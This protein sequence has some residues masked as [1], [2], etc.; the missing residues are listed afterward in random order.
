MFFK[1]LL[2]K[3]ADAG[4][5]AEQQ[6]LIA[7]A[8][9]SPD[10][11]VRRDACRQLSDLAALRRLAAEDDDAAVR[12]LAGARYRR[13]LCGLDAQSPPLELRLGELGS[14][15]DQ[16]LI[17]DVAGQ[18]EE[19]E[20]R[21]AAIARLSRPEALAACAIDDPL[22]AN[23]LA[24]AERVQDKAALEHIA[25]GI[26]KRDKR[27][28]RLARERLRAIAE[29]EERPRLA[30]EQGEALCTKLERLGRFDNWVQDRAV[31]D[32]LDQQWE[33]LSTDAGEPL[34]ERY[35]ALRRRFLD[36]YDAYAREHAAQLAA[37][38]AR[39]E[40]VRTR[41]ALIAELE[42]L[43]ALEDLAALDQGLDDNTRAWDS[44]P[45]P[46]PAA[47]RR[48]A[49]A[50][51]AALQ[52]LRSHREHLR[53]RRRHKQTSERLLGEARQL[54]EQGGVPERKTLRALQGRFEVL[55]DDAPQHAEIT[56]LLEQLHRRFDKHCKQLAR[57]LAA[58]PERLAEL[59][60]HFDQ[61]ELKKAEP[62]YQSIGATLEHA[63]A[64]GLPKTDIA[65]VDAH[66]KQIA[67][68]LHELRQWRRWSADEHRA[69]LCE[70][71]ETLAADEER[72]L[73]QAAARL[74]ELQR[75]W[76]ELDRNGAPPSNALWQRFHE[77][78]ERVHER[79]RPFLD[80][81]AALRAEN[82][83]QRE[84]LCKRLEEFMEQVDWERID[85][86]K[87]ARAEREMRQA[88]AALG[89]VEGRHHKPL[90]GRFRRDLR[91]LDKALSEERERNQA[92]KRSLIEQMQALADEPDLRRAIDAAKALQQQ[93]HTTVAGRQ[94]DEN[95]LWK[96]FRGASDAVFARRQAEHEAKTAELRDNQAA[97]EA[98][99][100]ELTVLTTAADMEPVRFEQALRALKTR[101]QD[102]EALPLPRSAAAGLARQWRAAL[103]EAGARLEA[104]RE[105]ARWAA[106]ERL[107]ARAA[108]LDE[109]AR[110][111]AA[112]VDAQAEDLKTDWSALPDLDDADA[113]AAL[114]ER[115]GE[116]LTALDDAAERAALVDRLDQNRERRRELCL[117][118]EIVAGVPSPA[119]LKEQRMALQVERLRGRMGEG[120]ADPLADAG[121]LLRDWY[122]STPAAADVDLDGRFTRVKEG[123]G[124]H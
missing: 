31:L 2:S 64:A 34:C 40:S 29:A 65:P 14:A 95:A 44:A 67:P 56:A 58:L 57:R 94:R 122:L 78:G 115:F 76:R 68:R 42:Q 124:A 123:L 104:L 81:Q 114:E 80:Q 41:E 6:Q 59:D 39:A 16:S 120:E 69:G 90:E 12:D 33:A 4:D 75:E 7:A 117:H 49:Q 25:K 30:R 54:L 109:T 93:W 88:W 100:Q 55:P 21:L 112:G 97:R 106:T 46:E 22:A 119:A 86:K 101:W 73:D 63:R 8:L 82:R 27:V 48:L 91:R 47:A 89:P 19:P 70:A 32:H 99:C 87:L 38:Q 77:A 111:L 66:L 26:G 5:P 15:D 116:V 92:H 23:R 96:S 45:E 72:P 35:Q 24:A 84:A 79:C 3:K 50:R 1:R 60:A 71:I 43:A 105:A 10:A 20:L 18:A 108:W 102:T 85:W 9:A 61:G 13:L 51:D 17:G 83:R 110:G 103:A 52:Q 107:A 37:E 98:I 28:Y 36:A 118:L 74:H 11:R 121:P 53:E 62:L 113:A